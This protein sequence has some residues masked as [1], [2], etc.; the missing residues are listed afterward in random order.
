MGTYF[1]LFRRNRNSNNNNN[2]NIFATKQC[3]LGY[4]HKK[5]KISQPIDGME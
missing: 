1:V 2:I 5:I 4:V 3:N